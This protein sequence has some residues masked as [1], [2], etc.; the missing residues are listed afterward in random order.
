M[1]ECITVVIIEK[2][3]YI[4]VLARL[5]HMDRSSQIVGYYSERNDFDRTSYVKR[6][7]RS[8]F[9]GEYCCRVLYHAESYV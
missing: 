1:D 4:L 3:K 8:L 9:E 6:L 7:V 5:L 2:T